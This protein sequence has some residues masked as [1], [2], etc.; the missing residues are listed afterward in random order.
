MQ[1]HSRSAWQ[2]SRNTYTFW[3]RSEPK[4]SILTSR[5]ALGSQ[6]LYLLVKVRTPSRNVQWLLVGDVA[7]PIPSGEGQNHCSSTPNC[8]V[9]CV[10]IPIPSGEGQNIMTKDLLW[11]VYTVAIPIPSG[12]GQNRKSQFRVYEFNAVA[13][14]IPSGE[15][16]NPFATSPHMG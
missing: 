15:G 8:G 9:I 3:W 16:Q 1:G 10:A 13:I 4:N 12:E 7:I 6:Y 14:P 5:I 2:G 11:K